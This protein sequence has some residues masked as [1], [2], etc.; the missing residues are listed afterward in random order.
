MIFM[1]ENVHIE[2]NI[3]NELYFISIDQYNIA[4]AA[5]IVMLKRETKLCI[6]HERYNHAANFIIITLAASG[7]VEGLKI[8]GNSKQDAHDM[9][10]CVDYAMRKIHRSSFSFINNKHAEKETLIHFDTCKS[11]QITSFDRNRYLVM[12][13]DDVIRFIH[14][15]LIPNKKTCI[16]LKVFK[17]FKNL[18]ETKLAKYIQIIHIDND[19]EYQGVLKDYLKNQ[20]IKHQVTMSYFSKFNDMIEW[21]NWMIM[22]MIWF[23]LY[24]LDYSLEFWREVV[25]VACYLSNRLSFRVLNGKTLFEAWFEY[26]S[27]VIHLRRWGCIIYAHISKQLRKKLD[28]KM[29]RGIFIEY[30]NLNDIYRIFDP[31]T[32]KII[33]IKDWII[34]ENE[35]WDFKEE[36]SYTS[37]V[38]NIEIVIL[39]ILVYT[40]TQAHSITSKRIQSFIIEI[41]TS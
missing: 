38:S 16:I 23:M 14:D 8:L 3:M 40:Q 13:I 34:S 35:F 22:K 31:S 9:N 15:F 2:M 21:Y 33:S 37:S 28:V 18:V 20:D 30:D 41:V 17:I 7:N 26:K 5:H 27:D 12:F 29:H 25:L 4:I 1:N 39:Q 24:H 32:N 36:T 10:I 19:M 6:W 11:M